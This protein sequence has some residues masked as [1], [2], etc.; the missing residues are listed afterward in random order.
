MVG[1]G[2]LLQR[3]ALSQVLKKSVTWTVGEAWGTL[4]GRNVQHRDSELCMRGSKQGGKSDL[5]GLNRKIRRDEIWELWE[6]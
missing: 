1:E 3:C 6:D 2:R 5:K 4:G